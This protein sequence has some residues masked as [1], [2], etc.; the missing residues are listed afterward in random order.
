MDAGAQSV[1]FKKKHRKHMKFQI[2][3]SNS[4]N[5]ESDSWFFAF[6]FFLAARLSQ[7]VDLQEEDTTVLA[8]ERDRLQVRVIFSAWKRGKQK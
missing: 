2:H 3:G 6:F 1:F 4:S 5:L 8:S 7:D